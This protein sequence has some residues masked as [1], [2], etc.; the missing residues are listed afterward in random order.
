MI[1]NL[2]NW[3]RQ[4]ITNVIGDIVLAA[5]DDRAYERSHQQHSDAA[6]A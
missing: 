4:N 2:M 3:H 6:S 5:I 1:L